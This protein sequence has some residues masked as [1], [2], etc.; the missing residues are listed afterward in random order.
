MAELKQRRKQVDRANELGEEV[1][2]R[3]STTSFGLKEMWRISRIIIKTKPAKVKKN[4]TPKVPIPDAPSDSP[5]TH[6]DEP[7]VLDDTKESQQETDLKRAGLQALNE[8]ADLHER[9][10]KCVK[11][12]I[13]R[14]YLTLLS[15]IFIWRK[16]ASSKVYGS[17]GGNDHVS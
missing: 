1:S 16:P 4:K 13:G 3:L 5:D 11:T 10:K 2:I 17:V 7:T 8:I 6:V 15:S 14:L 9:V 12:F